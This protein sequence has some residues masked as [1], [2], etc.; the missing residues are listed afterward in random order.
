MK[1][2]ADSRDVINKSTLAELA[3]FHPFA[4]VPDDKEQIF[5]FFLLLYI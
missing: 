1:K 5:V 4:H 2:M 3:L